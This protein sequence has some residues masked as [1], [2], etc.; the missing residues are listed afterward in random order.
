MAFGWFFRGP[1]GPEKM[2]WQTIRRPP[3]TGDGDA[4]WLLNVYKERTPHARRLTALLVIGI[5]CLLTQPFA[6]GQTTTTTTTA[7]VDRVNLSAG[8]CLMVKP[9]GCRPDDRPPLIVC[10]HETDTGAQV[11]LDFWRGLRSPIPAMLIAPEHHMPGWRETDMPCIQA[12]LEYLQRHAGY[13]THRVLLTGYSAGGAMSFH[14]LYT[15]KFPA[16][17]VAA[18]ANYVPPSITAEMVAARRDVPIFYAVGRKDINHDRMAS[19]IALLTQHG[20]PL[21]LIRPEIGHRLDPEV[22]QQAMDWFVQTSTQ[23]TLRRI[24]QAVETIGQRAYAG[25]LTIVEPIVAQKRWH[26][27]EV[28]AR[29]EAAILRLEKPGRDALT[30]IDRLIAQGQSLQAVDALRKLD[31][32]YGPSRVGDEVRLRLERL[33]ADERVKVGQQSRQDTQTENASRRAL[34]QAQRMVVNRQY[35]Q[36]RQQCDIII[37][38]YPGTDAAVRAKRLLEQ[39]RRAGK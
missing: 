8:F 4:D 26:P 24:D 13:D 38:S 1:C 3:R 22:G 14:L 19:S 12:M 25:G 20:G 32:Q 23:Q 37:R 39:L 34:A 10:L 7:A 36:A 6:A 17:F 29:A 33:T 15:E 5:P 35:E 30:E 31:A 18:T 9:P 27:P 2:E 21:T 11:I 28:V 16:T